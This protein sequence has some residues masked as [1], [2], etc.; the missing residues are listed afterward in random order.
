MERGLKVLVCC[1]LVIGSMAVLTPVVFSDYGLKTPV[2]NEVNEAPVVEDIGDR[3]IPI[4]RYPAKLTG[5]VVSVSAETVVVKSTDEETN[6]TEEM[7]LSITD[8]MK[9][10]KDGVE[11]AVSDLKAGD[12][13][14]LWYVIKVESENTADSMDMG[15]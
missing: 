5:E 1:L 11:T 3:Y 2:T 14:S 8:I 7:I 13:V 4:G 6:M 12:K 10:E 9:A 15:K